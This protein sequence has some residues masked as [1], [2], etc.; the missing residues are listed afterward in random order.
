[1]C[2]EPDAA[3]HIQNNIIGSCPQT[4]ILAT[5]LGQQGEA[6]EKGGWATLETYINPDTGKPYYNSRGKKQ[7]FTRYSDLTLQFTG[8]AIHPSL[9]QAKND[10]TLGANITNLS[11]EQEN[12]GMSGKIWKV[13]NG[14]T[15]VRA[16][17]Q[18]MD[19]AAYTYTFDS[20]SPS[21][22][23]R[24]RLKNVG[25]D[26]KVTVETN[27]WF[28][29]FLGLYVRF[30][31]N[32]GQPIKISNLPD[33]TVSEFPRELKGFDS[34][35]DLLAAL[36]A[37]EFEI[38][39]IPVKSNSQ[40]FT[41]TMPEIA[42]TAVILAGGMGHG[43]NLYPDAVVKPGV[44]ST[45][46]IDLA[47]PAIFLAL[48]AATTYPQFAKS[49][50]K[51]EVR[52]L[53]QL[54]TNAAFGAVVDC[55]FGNS[56]GL[57]VTAK[58]LGWY[59][60][61][62]GGWC[63][64]EMQATLA[65]GEAIDGIPFVGTILQAVAAAGL[66]A[67]LSE[68]SAEVATSPKIYQYNLVFKHDVTVTVSPDPDDPFGFPST[69]T[70]YQLLATFDRGTPV[71]SDMLHMPSSQQSDPIPYT[72]EGLP[73][74]GTV[75]FSVTFYSDSGWLAGSG[76]TEA[77]ANTVGA[78]QITIKEN[79]VPL[80]DQ[81]V[82]QH[83]QKTSLDANGNLTWVAGS[84]PTQTA[85][86]LLCENTDGSLCDPVCITVSETNA[87]I[88]YSFKAYSEG[89]VPWGGGVPAQLFTFASMSGRQNPELGHGDSGHGF[90]EIVRMVYDLMGTK[91]NNFYLD[92][93]GGKIM[94]RQIR[95]GIDQ[96]PDFDPPG[97][98][99]AWGRFYNPSDALLLHPARQLISI[100]SELSKIEVLPLSDHAM[101]D[102]QAP[103]A[104][105]Y[106]GPGSREGLVKGPVCAAVN[107]QGVIFILE[108]GN[109]RIQAFDL[110]ANPVPYFPGGKYFAPLKAES[111][112]DNVTFI[113]MAAEHTGFLYVLSYLP[114]QEL[115]EYRMDIYTPK[116]EFL[117]R[118][119]GFT[120]AKLCVDFWR[121]IY[122]LNYE[123][124]ALP[125]G[126]LPNVTEPSVSEWIPS[127]P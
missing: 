82:Y 49:M 70:Q 11:P 58:N 109:L 76:M 35:D 69:A 54:I 55:D 102:A 1:V 94:V 59:L 116:G 19:N 115:Y 21:H 5:R 23:F 73:Y 63:V 75:S 17:T 47:A 43:S 38:L 4:R 112:P 9:E 40:S 79:K 78:A 50:F 14:V 37:P 74:G 95:L 53:T 62:K 100:N 86:D 33:E 77:M 30:L 27:N 60:L 61:S 44:V 97:S 10:R 87:A 84:A 6:T 118:T 114:R 46:L 42:S 13:Q 91:N 85:A 83:K 8:Q 68:T 123:H 125:D 41:F 48:Y 88:G 29:R 2:G 18:T 34:D 110:H 99:L 108:Q 81:T 107:Q 36:I 20:D 121:N 71:K 67:S 51:A 89:I 120:A 31:D 111:D 45:A 32:V 92:T 98:N 16:Q 25:D 28:V 106:S 66:A 90:A 124:L 65:E 113:D 22:G 127:T 39:G 15:T 56:A 57:V 80:T 3:A 7:Y 105:A 64:D 101:A 93:S 122:A 126:S 104:C 52:F 119:T 24:A 12:S 72:F 103:T 117:S 26:R 96:K